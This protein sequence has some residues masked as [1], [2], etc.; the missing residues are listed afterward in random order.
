M[1]IGLI[2]ILLALSRLDPGLDPPSSSSGDY[3]LV[4]LMKI[5]NGA[6]LGIVK[7]KKEGRYSC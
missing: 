2:F 7:K 1:L 5:L 4:L 3:I 6:K